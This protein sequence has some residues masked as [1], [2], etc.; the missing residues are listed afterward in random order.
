MVETCIR[1]K[2]EW[3][4]LYRAVD[5]HGQK[6]DFLLT[7]QRDQEAALWF[8]EE[9]IRRHGMPEKI[10]I[11]GSEANAAAIKRDNQEHGTLI[12]IRQISYLNDMIEQ[13]HR[14]VKRVTCPMLGC[15]SFEAAQVTLGVPGASCSVYKPN[16]P[17]L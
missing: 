14:G 17:D 2:G 16:T 13:D 12:E 7:E 1:V 11:D 9:A 4:Y 3:R 6:I 10:T 8:L 15:K 5:M